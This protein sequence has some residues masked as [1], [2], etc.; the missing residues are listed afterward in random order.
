MRK[1]PLRAWKLLVAG[2]GLSFRTGRYFG[3]SMLVGLATGFV[4]VGFRYMIE[5]GREW[6]TE[7][8][9][10]HRLLSRLSDGA[11]FGSTPPRAVAPP[12]PDAGREAPQ[13]PRRRV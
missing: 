8:V 9:G 5:C 2:K 10:H 1:L 12:A 11:A 6:I 3:E 13:A 4:V 7:G